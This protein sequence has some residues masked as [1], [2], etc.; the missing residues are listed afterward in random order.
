MYFLT[1]DL[2]RRRRREWSDVVGP[3]CYTIVRNEHIL[4]GI[5]I[6]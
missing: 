3:A 6:L 5:I 1:M 2:G 4:N